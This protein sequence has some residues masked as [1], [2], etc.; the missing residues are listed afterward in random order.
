[1]KIA[2]YGLEQAPRSLPIWQCI[3]ED[4]GN[5]PPARVAKVLGV[6]VRTVYRWNRDGQAPRAACMALF[7]LTRWGR[8]EV[9]CQAVN[10]ATVAVGYANALLR[11]NK[12]LQVEL[13]RVLALNESGA[14]NSPL[15]RDADIS[16]R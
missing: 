3:L 4:L 1:M 7:W 10:D 5:P 15:I 14:A 13:A 16:A 9:H 2:L 8:S 6:A 11:E 12:K